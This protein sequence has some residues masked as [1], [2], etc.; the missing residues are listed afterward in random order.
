GASFVTL[1]ARADHALRGCLGS[2]DAARPLAL[3]V[4]ENA[5]AAALRDPRFAP[6]TAEEVSGLEVSISVLG[7]SVPLEVD[8]EA[9]LLRVLRP[10]VDGLVLQDGARRGVFLPAVWRELPDARE[11]L[12]AL[13]RKAGLPP[14][15]WSPTTRVERFEVREIGK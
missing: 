1:R 3:D 2:L 9:A 12:A 5:A 11:F 13:R 7:P 10:G 6:V 8:S 15:H 4:V 14:G